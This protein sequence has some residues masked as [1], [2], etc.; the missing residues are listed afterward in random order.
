MRR[1]GVV[2]VTAVVSALGWAC[3]DAPSAWEPPN[4]ES[5][6]PAPRQLSFSP[7]DDR[8]PAWSASG[9]SVLY[10]AEGFGDLARSDAVLVSVPRTGGVATAVFPLLQPD[11]VPAPAILAPAVDTASGRVAFAQLL[12]AGGSVC[13]ADATSCEPTGF[14]PPPPRLRL[15]RVRVRLPGASA[16]APDEPVLPLEFDG[17]E[18]DATREL[19]GVTGVWVT[20]LHPF[21][22]RFKE[23]DELPFR[24]SWEPGG[25]RLVTSDGLR[26]LLWTPGQPASVPVPGTEDGSSPT[27][28]PD[29]SRIA[30]TWLERGPEGGASCQHF[31]DSSKGG[32]IA[33]VEERTSWPIARFVVA[34]VPA[35]GG[36]R[37]ELAEGRDPAWSPDGGW[38]YF[39]RPDGVWRM[40][41]GGGTA[42]FVPGTEGGTQPAVAPNGGELAFT[43]RT[44]GGARN[45]WVVGVPP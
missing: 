42:T 10:V 8:S 37:I 25:G 43:R 44:A 39:V 2:A 12:S 26:L 9:D 33:C 27:W 11:G 29:G 5:P 30:Y 41:A 35:E 22:R 16:T 45:V 7:G 13:S 36:T 14:L 28:S 32:G 3:H 21:Q 31:L 19:F 20:R 38:I 6:G 23:R 1:P 18:F 24:A 15:G 4:G 40:P 17:V 34:A